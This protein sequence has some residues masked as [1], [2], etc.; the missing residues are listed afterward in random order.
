[1]T[2]EERAQ[3]ILRESGVLKYNNRIIARPERL[4]EVMARAMEEHATAAVEKETSLIELMRDVID[5]GAGSAGIG[6]GEILEHLVAKHFEVL[7][8]L[9]KAQTGGE[10][11]TDDG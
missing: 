9:E 6:I 11:E 5:L 4:V 7:K 8:R 1:M 10:K 2:A 3:A